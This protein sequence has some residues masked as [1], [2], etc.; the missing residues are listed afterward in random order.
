MLQVC[1]DHIDDRWSSSVMI[2]LISLQSDVTQAVLS[3]LLPASAL[4]IRWPSCI[5]C[6]D[7]IY[8]NGSKACATTIAAV[9]MTTITS[10]TTAT[11][12]GCLGLLIAT[13]ARQSTLNC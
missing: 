2:G 5:V 3:T 4:D 8:I 7:S 13:A 12:I 11:T 6:E 9:I 1:I 10:A